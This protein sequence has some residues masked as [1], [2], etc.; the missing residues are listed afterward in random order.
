[1]RLYKIMFAPPDKRCCVQT[2]R[3]PFPLVELPKASYA[4]Y[5]SS[6]HRN[7]KKLNKLHVPLPLAVG[8]VMTRAEC[9]WYRTLAQMRIDIGLLSDNAVLVCQTGHSV[10]SR[11]AE[12]TY[13]LH[14]VLD[15]G[16]LADDRVDQAALED[17]SAGAWSDRFFK[18]YRSSRILFE[19]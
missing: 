7:D 2:Q 3:N 11:A 18:V 12:I 15:A 16:D 8:T 9:R 10:R 13:K 6:N 19:A 4:P 1:M 5:T 14:K 17:S